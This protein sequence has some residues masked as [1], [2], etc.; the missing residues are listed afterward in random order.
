MVKKQFQTESKRILDIMVNSIYTN[1]EIFLRELISNA[2]DAIDKLCYISL[3]DDKVS[4]SRDDYRITISADKAARTITISDNGVG[5]T[6][7][8]LENNLGVIA[9]SGSLQFKKDM[10][11]KGDDTSDII[12]QFGVGLYS[13]FMIAQRVT[14]ITKA[15][16]QE[17]GR[18]WVSSGADGYTIEECD[19]E[20][21]GSDII[22]DLKPDTETENYSEFLDDWRLRSLIKRYSD[23]I[24]WPI[25]MGDETVNSMVPIWQRPKDETPDEDCFKFY[26]ETFFDTNDPVSVVRVNA[27]GMVSYKAMLFIPGAVPYNYYTT[28]YEQGLKLYASGVMIMEKC[29]DLIPEHFRF[30]RGVVDS[31]DLSLNISRELLQ[32]TR[33]LKVIA[34]NIEK[35]IKA[36]LKKLMTNEPEK[37]ADFF[38]S[39]GLQ[40]KYGIVNNY[41][42]KKELLSDLLMFYSAKEEKLISLEEYVKNMAEGQEYIYFACADSVAIAQGLPQ[43][44]PVKNKG[45]D[46]LYMTEHVDEF[47]VNMLENYMEKRFKSV[48]DDDLGFELENKSEESM[49]D[50]QPVLDFVKETLGDAIHAAKISSKLVSY[51][52]CLGTEGPVTLEMEKYFNSIPHEEGQEIKAQRV[53]EL[54]ADHDVFKALKDAVEN[55]KDKAARYCHILNDLALLLAGM[56]VEDPSKF[57]SNVWNLMK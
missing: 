18:K 11:E 27:E 30:V 49:E 10:A 9:K 6:E 36:E 39:F 1:R 7:D 47:V 29:A 20:G 41:G 17:T 43:T 35:K 25:K 44:E 57:S 33:Q 34:S 48:C 40:L 52:V 38:N 56:P 55:D 19:K 51:P 42:E 14:V 2:S 53:L 32:Q 22:L 8:E 12:G 50:N 4:L 54:N 28:S 23:Y 46:I 16:G 24:R 45:Y 3:T 5:M 13:A 31:P 26:K 37:Y 21:W 15:Y